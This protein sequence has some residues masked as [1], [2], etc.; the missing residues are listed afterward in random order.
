V[1]K[2]GQKIK[3]E[4]TCKRE[5][6]VT[7]SIVLSDPTLNTINECRKNIETGGEEESEY[8]PTRTS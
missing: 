6:G 4:R 7:E 5:A 2:A 1:E 8:E 3:E